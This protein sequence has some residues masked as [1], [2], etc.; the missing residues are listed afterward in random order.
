M[1][2]FEHVMNGFFATRIA[3]K[4]A[5]FAQTREILTAREHFVHI[6]LVSGVENEGVLR[7]FK[8]PVQG[9]CQFDDSKIRAEMPARL[10]DGGDEKLANL[11]GKINEFGRRECLKIRGRFDPVEQTVFLFLRVHDSDSNGP[12]PIRRN[13]AFRSPRSAP[14]DG[15]FRRAADRA[16]L[17]PTR[18][19]IT[20]RKTL[21]NVL[22]RRKHVR[23]RRSLRRVEVPHYR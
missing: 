1:R 18:M 7:G 11:A 8:D 23:E 17:H 3:R 10:R 15:S 22:P 16:G 2:R 13:G 21:R 12:M 4:T 20:K 6:G 14:D 19:C 5:R 9:D